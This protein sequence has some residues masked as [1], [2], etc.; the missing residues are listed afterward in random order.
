LHGARISSPGFV[1]VVCES[2]RREAESIAAAAGFEDVSVRV[3]PICCRQRAWEATVHASG[4]EQPFARMLL[5]GGFCVQHLTACNPDPSR[6]E[7]CGASQCLYLLAGK[8]FVDHSQGR[9]LYVLSSGWLE[10]WEEHIRDWG[11]DQAVARECFGESVRGLLLLDS[12]LYPDAGGRL[13][14]LG[15]F[16]RRPVSSVPVG[17]DMFR[18]WVSERI[19]NSR[20]KSSEAAN[21]VA[22]AEV[23]R[24]SA[25][26]AMVLDLLKSLADVR[27]ESE[28]IRW[29]I[30]LLTTLYAPESAVFDG[31]AR[32]G[33]LQ[34]A[35]WTPTERG[36]RLRIRCGETDF[37]SIRIEGLAFPESSER[38]RSS[39]LALGS[40]MALAIGKA[41]SYRALEMER[42]RAKSAARVKNE[43]LANMSH[44]IRTPMNGIIGF[45]QLALDTQL[46]AD[47]RDYLETVER[48]AQ[49]LLRVISDILDLSKIEAG[50]LELDRE[51]F[52]LRETVEGAARTIAPEALRKG[53]D[54][55][56]DIDA[57]VP[58]ALL[59]DSTRLRQVL[60]NLLGNAAKFTANG[61][62]RVEVHGETAGDA[63]PLLHFVVRDS[64]IGIP[65]E[66]QQL[67]FEPFR[68]A[69]GSISRKYGGTGLGLSI[70]AKLSRSMQGKI[71]LESEVGRGSAFHFTACFGAVEVPQAPVQAPRV[72]RDPHRASLSIL[73]V[74][75]DLTSRT[76]TSMVLT[77][78]GHSVATAVNGVEALGLV[79]RRLFD[80]ILMDVQMPRMDGFEATERIRRRESQ[81]GGRVPIVAMT[82]HAMAGGRERCLAAGMDD[83]ISKPI[84]MNQLLAIIGTS[85]PKEPLPPP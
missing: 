34:D 54:L 50:H 35:S 9:G 33:D 42:D 79:E 62:I 52:S 5:A 4:A 59:G 53:L 31:P 78:N 58:D 27:S 2:F 57:D 37:G 30:D 81:T 45:T 77:R 75:D 3:R 84:D 71:W 70:S 25:H 21:R 48:S 28:V 51:P 41:R 80:V 69:D 10:H 24:V 85:P 66:Q 73:L 14:A 65:P 18:G 29:G 36:F 68:Q 16:V 74:E 7:I 6:I 12:G 15:E 49:T 40:V 63:G 13:E 22:R 8:S 47:Q 32:A 60:L 43:F 1:L 56:W 26:S 17:L 83:Y 61:F 23:Q 76:L 19:L 20:L 64:G 46:T 38:Y 11:F 82:A 55:S 67:I 39:A 44:E 72:R